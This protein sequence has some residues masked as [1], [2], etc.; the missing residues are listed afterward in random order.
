MFI[1]P[2]F[3]PVVLNQMEKTDALLLK[4]KDVL[5]NPLVAGGAPRDWFFNN[6]ATDVD[7]FIDPQDV[8]LLVEQVKDCLDLPVIDVVTS[9]QL[10]ENYRSTYISTVISF[11]FEG[12][13]FQLILKNTIENPLLSFPASVSCITYENFCIKPTQSFLQSIRSSSMLITKSCTQKYERKIIK[14][15]NTYSIRY[16][17]RIDIRS[18]VGNTELDW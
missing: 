4:L 10:P 16:V 2:D 9:E 5:N 13:S 15:F 1:S 12:V 11:R 17:D 3:S 6:T 7:V 18:I 8:Q 14:K